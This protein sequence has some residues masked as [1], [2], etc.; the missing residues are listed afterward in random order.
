MSIRGTEVLA[1]NMAA[2][3]KLVANQGGSGSSKT[4]SLCQLFILKALTERNKIFTI[5]RKTGPA[6]KSTVQKDFL[7]LLKL[8]GYYREKDYEIGNGRYYLNSNEINFISV[9]QATKLKGRK[10]NYVW[11]NEANE[12]SE[13]IFNQLFMRLRNPSLD[14]KP[15]QLFLDYNPS[16]EYHWIYEKVLP[17]PDCTYIHSTYLDNPFLDAETVRT[18]ESYRLIDPNYWLTYGLGE[19]AKSHVSIYL[20]WEIIDADEYLNQV[21]PSEI[22]KQVKDFAYGLDFGFNHPTALTECAY[23]DDF[24]IW[25]QKIYGRH[26]NTPDL[27]I[28]MQSAGLDLNKYIFADPSRPEAIDLIRRAGYNVRSAENSV[29]DG[30]ESIQSK[31]LYITSTST[32]LIKEIKAYKW[33]VRD[34]GTILNHEPVKI[35]DDGM[36]SGRYGTY[37]QIKATGSAPVF[38]FITGS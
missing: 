38:T 24:N 19:K 14:G 5:C 16:D 17:R 29:V 1:K 11:I 7:D 6:L 20:N 35:N 26:L 21:T 12:V 3:T 25:H 31:K 4:I 27:I 9:D 15:N 28:K 13:E 34:D 2:T 33:K 30:I 22:R 23:A 8:Y 10:H 37:S 32:D 18:I 36:D